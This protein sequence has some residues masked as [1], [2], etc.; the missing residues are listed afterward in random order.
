MS[1]L[2]LH[3]GIHCTHIPLGILEFLNQATVALLVF[4]SNHL[5]V[6]FLNFLHTNHISANDQRGWRRGAYLN[7]IV[8]ALSV[9][10]H[11]CSCFG[12]S[13]TRLVL[14]HDPTHKFFAGI[15]VH[16]YEVIGVAGV[17]RRV[18]FEG[19][20]PDLGVEGFGY[21]SIEVSPAVLS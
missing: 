5:S 10:V 4:L 20:S 13:N 3:H 1:Y 14:F 9:Q 19:P 11:Q 6:R 7:L 16:G 2:L 18:W 15:G 21:T 12:L 17:T 8:N